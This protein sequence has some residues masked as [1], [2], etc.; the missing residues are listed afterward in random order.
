M[1]SVEIKIE[2]YTRGGVYSV[3]SKLRRNGIPVRVG[4]DDEVQLCP[5]W[6]AEGARVIGR[7]T[8][9]VVRDQVQKRLV[10]QYEPPIEKGSNVIAVYQRILGYAKKKPLSLSTEGRKA[11]TKETIDRSAAGVPTPG[12]CPGCRMRYRNRTCRPS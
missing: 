4:P 10:Y 6:N 9:T 5:V 11:T 7:G 3:V 1:I 8:M 2:D 12:L